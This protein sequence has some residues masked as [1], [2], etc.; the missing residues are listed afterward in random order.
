MTLVSEIIPITGY[1]AVMARVVE[2][3]MIFLYA[4]KTKEMIF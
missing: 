2:I 3:A 4:G 1:V